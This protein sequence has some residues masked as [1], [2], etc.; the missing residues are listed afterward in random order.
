MYVESFHCGF[1]DKRAASELDALFC[2]PESTGVYPV[3]SCTECGTEHG[4]DADAARRCCARGQQ[5]GVKAAH[6]HAG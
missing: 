3:Y 4:Q 2:C 6:A 5:E 1:C